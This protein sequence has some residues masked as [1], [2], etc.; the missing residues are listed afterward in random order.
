MTPQILSAV[1]V[2]ERGGWYLPRGGRRWT[3]VSERPPEPRAGRLCWWAP[4][5][6]PGDG[7]RTARGQRGAR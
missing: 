1:D 6:P 7:W 2:A 5:A 3:A 4:S